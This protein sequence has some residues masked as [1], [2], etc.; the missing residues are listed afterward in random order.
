MADVS[1]FAI[2]RDSGMRSVVRLLLVTT[3]ALFISA[4]ASNDKQEEVLPE[5][6]YYENARDAMNSGNFNEAEQN[7]DYL[8]TY[9][10][11]GR[12]AEQAQLD[13]IYARYQNL[14]LEGA[15]AAADRFLR[16]N[17][18]SDH[19][20]YALYM[21]GLAS[22]NLDI[23][24]AARYFPVDVSARDPGEQRQAFR[25]FSE[26]LNRYPS[27]EYAPDAR[28]RMIAIRNR[29]AELEL[30]AARY[31]I[32]REAYIAANNR[33]RY[34]IENYSTTPS[35]EEA[36]IILAETF[37]FMDLKKGATDAVAMLKENFPDSAAFNENGEF[38]PDIL[39]RE[40]RSLSSVVT[41]GL[42]GDE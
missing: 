19:A 26:L 4:C 7:L 17:P 27:S 36:L 20:D 39:K 8:E 34:I 40:D 9:Y 1:N 12:Y 22:Y 5:Q 33:A 13:L 30:Y 41:F 6:T 3:A 28:Q 24:L 25:D 29:L 31:Y 32:S 16:L 21:R 37:R 15:R 11:F 35:V 10:P 38:Q 2:I 23:G 18:Q 14:D 42:M